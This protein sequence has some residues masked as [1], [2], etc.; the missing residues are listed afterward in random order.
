MQQARTYTLDVTPDV[1]DY[2]RFHCLTTHAHSMRDRSGAE[3][4]AALREADALWRGEPLAGLAGSWAA[5][6]RAGLEARRLTARVEQA[7]LELRTGDFSGP[8]HD[9]S[10]LLR[11]QPTNE[12]IAGHLMVAYYGCGR[13]ADALHV[14][15]HVRRR[16][17]EEL[18]VDPGKDFSRIHRLILQQAPMSELLP[19]QPDAVASVP[20]VNNL[21]AHVDIVGREHELAALQ[22]PPGEGT[23]IA[24]QSISGMAGVGKS[25]LAFHAARKLQS[26]YPDGQLYVDLRAHSPRRRPLTPSS[27]LA[28]LLRTLGLPSEGIPHSIEERTALWRSLLRDRRAVV[29]LDDAATA[30]Q[31]RPLLPLGSSSLVL[32]TSRQRL[33]GV[34]GIRSLFVDV[35]PEPD[36]MALF[37]RLVGPERARD[38][39][40]VSAVVELCG[41]LPLAIELAAGRLRSRP[42][43]T[44][45]HLHRKL[46][47][48]RS[49][50]REIRD[51]GSG[52][53]RAFELSYRTLTRKQQTAFRR[54]GLHF[55]PDFGPHAAAALIGTS[56]DDA[57][58]LVEG[59]LDSS[60]LT[61]P[62]AER[63]RFHDL[64]GEYALT[65]ARQDPGEEADALERL[66]D[67]YLAA[68]LEADLSAHPRR[69]RVD[70]VPERS[71]PPPPEIP[72]LRDE[73]EA[74]TW[75]LTEGSAL[76]AAEDY[77][78]T[79]GSP[80][81]AAH[82]AHVLAMFLDAEGLWDEAELMHRHAAQHWH[83]HSASRA[84]SLARIDLSITHA[85]AGRYTEAAAAGQRALT[86]AR[87]AGDPECTAE[88]LHQLG[89]LHW[90]RGEYRRMLELQQEALEIRIRSND[91]WNQAR[92]T[93]TIGIAHLHLGNSGASF[94]YFQEA[95][96]QFREIGDSRGEAQA[97]NNLADAHLHAG[98]I[99]SARQLFSRSLEIATESSSRWEQAMTQLNLGST[100]AVPEEMDVI[101][102]L[103]GE[104]LASFQRLGD[105]RNETITRIALGDAFRK[106]GRHEESLEQHRLSL[107]LARSIGAGLEE[108]QALRGLGT[109]ERHL[110]EHTTARRHLEESLTLTASMQSPEEEARSQDSLAELELSD[111]RIDQAT[112]LWKS[113]FGIFIHL[114]TSEAARIKQR[115]RYAQD[116]RG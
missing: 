9:L 43:W 81:K 70:I 90:H 10:L 27:A 96:L 40:Q 74:R 33:T 31:I 49:R 61:E 35:L 75:L 82:L 86:V 16:L 78:R 76:V 79:H 108:A 64:L 8:A 2:H 100:L 104:A 77:A 67:F 60:L 18:G 41:R 87:G 84:E 25:L 21:P 107:T 57:E 15:E 28:S 109:A 116:L 7:D 110:G 42:A 106:A 29:V 115:I 103:Y 88:A 58:H 48:S 38:A 97:L 36:A 102:D 94:R 73:L 98:D 80:H 32:L 91:Q 92:S 69:A 85:H 17:R 68:A 4:L 44:V 3:A 53:D 66:V 51:R 23:I 111:G 101:L 89:I 1:I 19:A 71:A 72:F 20:A 63:Y 113:A 54:L 50:L 22:E 11:Q 55:G 59:L 95:L 12:T 114:D 39:D 13:Q 46:A 37:T 112:V 105:R 30:E 93:N 52:I 47:Q 62:E 65:L 26:A 14:Y 24:L 83:E 45:R 34:P 56:V 5:E 99:E 6:I